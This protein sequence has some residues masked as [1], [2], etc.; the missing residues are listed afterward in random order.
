MVELRFHHHRSVAFKRILVR[1]AHR[2]P[3]R[4]LA[5]VLLLEQGPAES[6]VG[7]LYGD[8]QPGNILYTESGE[9]S[10]LLDWELSAI[11]AQ[12][13]DLGWLLMI[14]DR[15]SFDPSWC[16]VNPLSP[17]EL[18]T[19]YEKA[20]GRR[21]AGIDWYRALAGYRMG[22]MTGLFTRLHREGRRHDPAW[23]KFAL[24]VPFLFGRAEALLRA[25]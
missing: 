6:P 18:I 25:R 9:I 11:G 21:C 2:T 22:V 17:E 10:G 14:G 19:I 15:Q 1:R 7:L 4:E 23:E 8:C 16:P 12:D 3:G 24:G 5:P 20:A 13:Y